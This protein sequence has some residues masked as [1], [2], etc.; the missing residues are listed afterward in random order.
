MTG[1]IQVSAAAATQSTPAAPPAA[2]GTTLEGIWLIQLTP[3]NEE[4]LGAHQALI[5]FHEDGTADADFSPESGNGAATTV[6]S[7]GRGEWL[8]QERVCR[9]SLIALMNDAGQRFAGTATIEAQAQLDTAGRALDGTF[10]F[11]VV[12]AGGQS[13]GD[14]SGRL[15]GESVPLEP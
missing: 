8:L 5:A 15:S 3:D 4:I 7:S 6:L 14:G 12:S 11:A 9:L 1:T 10:E 13:L 2:D